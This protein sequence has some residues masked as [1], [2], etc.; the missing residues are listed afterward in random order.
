MLRLQKLSLVGFL[1]GLL[2]SSMVPSAAV[3]SGDR[4]RPYIEEAGIEF[5]QH[6]LSILGEE[7]RHLYHRLFR[8][9]QNADW[10]TARKLIAKLENPILMGHVTFQRLMHPTGYRSTFTE[11]AD[12]LDQYADLV[13]AERI[14][15]LAKKRRP[16]GNT[17]KLRRPTMPEIL[18]GSTGSAQEATSAR[19][20]DEPKPSKA[21]RN[22]RGIVQQNIAQGRVSVMW[23][24]LRQAAWRNKLTNTEYVQVLGDIAKGYVLYN[25]DEKAIAV[26]D[27]TL[28][29]QADY[30]SQAFWW[31]GL[32]AWRQGDFKTAA[33]FFTFLGNHPKTRADFAAAASFWAWRA[34]LRQGNITL[35]HQALIQA[36]NDP[37]SFYGQL[38]RAALSVPDGLD[39]RLKVDNAR[40]LQL[41]TKNEVLKRILALSE[42]G[43]YA[44]AQAEVLR[45]R[46]D[47]KPEYLS[48]LMYIADRAGM[49][50]FTLKLGRKQ[51][52]AGG[53][54]HDIS[55]YPLP[56]WQ[57]AEGY[58]ID[59]ALLYAV[60]LKE[61]Q[62]VARIQSHAG[63]KGL[64]QLMPNTAKLMQKRL[65]MP[66]GAYQD[67]VVNIALGQEYL[68]Y[69]FTLP[70]I[71]FNLIYA[72]AGYN[73]GPGRVNEW[74][75]KLQVDD[76]LLFIEIIPV[77]E[78]RQY[79]ELVLGNLWIYRKRLHQK[80]PSMGMLLE[81]NWPLYRRLDFLDEVVIVDTDRDV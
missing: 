40:V 58:H 73:A 20:I 9:Q 50:N 59:R 80:T 34:E 62:F 81:G 45:L 32:A 49:A 30:P 12:W 4:F 26:A 47:D 63:A 33:T 18:S 27:E 7:D 8:V 55:R 61:S 46:Y 77:R 42:V 28:R 75:K 57:F 71:D 52:R 74:R 22:I 60:I 15:R 35:A 23:N 54:Q 14:Y 51:R 24:R 31:A 1:F 72:L 10:A 36:K 79:I 56:R 64:M 78:T 69:L 38:A 41:M 76:P 16:A 17:R 44:L 37:Y 66:V 6:T 67:P 43:Q 21:L 53:V 48:T 70:E 13:G 39:W 29:I 25:V 11:L 2:L 3:A 65:K 19:K 5:G 68:K